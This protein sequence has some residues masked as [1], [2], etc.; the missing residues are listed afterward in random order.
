MSVSHSP[1]NELRDAAARLAP[2][3]D[4]AIV[5]SFDD[6]FDEAT[7]QQILSFSQALER[8][9]LPGVRESTPGLSTVTIYYDPLQVRL[10]DV[11]A[12]LERLLDE[13]P[14]HETPLPQRTIEIPV[15]YGGQFG[16][17][18]PFVAEHSGLK[19]EEVVE[20]HVAGV[21]RVYM[22][23]FVPGFPYLGGLS[24]RITAPRR[25]TPRLKT[26]AGSVGIAGEQ[27]G[28][29]PLETPGGWQLI[30]R[31]PLR[32]FRTEQSPPSL[33]EP[34]DRVRFRAISDNEF[35]ALA[36]QEAQP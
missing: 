20:L 5:V 31:T 12:R 17:D 32:L 2:L 11:L 23:G 8:A 15:C 29:Y 18:L 1:P 26:P 16:P 33:L 27:T 34:G 7:L 3:G 36:G 13:L 35:Q 6:A 24:P 10:P 14:K 28:V 4:R 21:Y 30:G 22:L 9:A 19:V 25:A